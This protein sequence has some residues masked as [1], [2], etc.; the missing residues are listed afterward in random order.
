MG[1]GHYH[2]EIQWSWIMALSA[3]VAGQ[4]GDDAGKTA[5]FDKLQT[6]AKRDGT[7]GEVY[8]SEAQ[9]RPWSSWLYRSEEPFSWGAAMT[10]EAL[11]S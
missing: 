5:A 8:R 9:S 1:L 2:D 11:D 10:L 7:V 3:K 6:L 4:M